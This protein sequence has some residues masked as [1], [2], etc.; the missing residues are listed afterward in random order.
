MRPFDSVTLRS[1][2]EFFEQGDSTT[3]PNPNVTL[4]LSKPTH[5]RRFD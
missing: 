2:G 4:S 1:P 5:T 3:R